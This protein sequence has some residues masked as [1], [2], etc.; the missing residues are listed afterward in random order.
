MQADNSPEPIPPGDS[1]TQ[2]PLRTRP[3]VGTSRGSERVRI[4][5]QYHFHQRTKS[6]PSDSDL[7]PESDEEGRSESKF[8]ARPPVRISCRHFALAYCHESLIDPR[9]HPS[10]LTKHLAIAHDDPDWFT[11]RSL[12]LSCHSRAVHL[13][14]SDRFGEFVAQS[15]AQMVEQAPD[16]CAPPADQSS[17]VMWRVYFAT[18]LKHAIGVRLKL[19]LRT[20][21]AWEYVVNVYDPNLTNHHITSRTA[22][23]QDLV[24]H[25]ET[26]GLLAFLRQALAAESGDPRNYFS[27]SDPDC[28]VGLFELR[29]LDTTCPAPLRFATDWCRQPRIRI[30]HGRRAWIVQAVSDG[31]HDL[32]D[33]DASPIDARTLG[34]LPRLDPSVLAYAMHPLDPGHLQAWRRVW[35]RFPSSSERREL[36]RG[37]NENRAHVLASHNALADY[38]LTTWCE[39]VASLP[40][41]SQVLALT[42]LDAQSM[43]PMAYALQETEPR[44]MN[45]LRRLV[46]ALIAQSPQ[47]GARVLGAP[48][49]QGISLV[50]SVVACPSEPVR[51]L[52][53]ALLNQ[54]PF[55]LKREVLVARAVGGIPLWADCL[56]ELDLDTLEG[57]VTLYQQEVPEDESAPLAVHMGLPVDHVVWFRFLGAIAE[58]RQQFETALAM[59]APWLTATT[60]NELIKRLR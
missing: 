19:K 25:P 44:L 12:S 6:L 37:L 55:P 49:G 48:T 2:R 8:G 24:D 17:I 9:F 58:D 1:P 10:S 29:D 5:G 15:F 22:K 18:T 57:L 56:A 4:N 38:A 43:H 40:L 21:G 34:A 60:L 50:S 51:V 30:A 39:M 46:G 35:E 47:D 3:Y 27:D 28:C 33:S 20:D 16:P 41:P 32:L 7:D 31:L 54:L 53:R 26:Y 36:L 59:I 11:T 23:L 52:W 42:D 14:P 45:G 13:L